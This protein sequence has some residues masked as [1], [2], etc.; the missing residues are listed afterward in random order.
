MTIKNV[1]K[2]DFCNGCG[3]CKLYSSSSVNIEFKET[4][5][6]K[7]NINPSQIIDKKIS[8]VCPFSDDSVNETILAKS[9]FEHSTDNYDEKVG[10]YSGIYTG[11]IKDQ[12]SRLSSS[13]GGLTT[14]IAKKLLEI[15]E[16]DAVIHVGF[17]SNKF[18]YA[19]SKT[20]TELDSELKK[21]SRYYPVTLDS[22]CEYIE[23]TNDKVVI[24]GIP[25]FIKSIRLLQHQGKYLNIK[26]CISLLCGHMKSSAFGE[27]LAWQIGITPK[28]LKYV[29]FRVKVEGYEASNYFIN[30][31]DIN[32]N[33]KEALN[34]SLFGSNWGLGF[35]RHKSCNYC[36][37]IAGE[38]ADVTLGDAWLPE[39]TKDYLGTNILVIRN[40]M[41]KKILDEN[42]DL[43]SLNKVDVDTF[44]QTQKGNYGNRRGGIIA[45]NENDLEWSPIK[46]LNLCYKYRG[47]EKKQAIY[48][49]RSKLSRLSIDNFIVAKKC[50]SL[51]VYR[52]LMF[53]YIIKYTYMSNGF[54]STLKYFFPLKLKKI[55]R[56][57]IK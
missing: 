7:A 24:I 36:D 40:K 10:F 3:G 33:K 34:S 12:D 54:F 44:Y 5:F 41:I 2:H 15:G 46:R 11:N 28:L 4:G 30:A 53:P 23:K 26:Y 43:L 55:I 21:K 17:K 1:I 45:M 50:H 13:S 51:V 37:D 8:S 42:K 20:S 14:F 19:I 6:F 38:L 35:F 9:L 49:Y 56:V 48:K 47:D 29:D 52:I 16:V 27:S 22:I 39:Y 32:G 31:F 57:L 25:C 18:E